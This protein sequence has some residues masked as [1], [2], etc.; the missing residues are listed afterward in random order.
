[1]PELTYVIPV[2]NSAHSIQSTISSI[3]GQTGGHSRVIVVDDGSTDE[4][5]NILSKYEGQLTLLRQPNMGPSAARNYGLEAVETEIVCFVDHDDYVIGP[6][7]SAVEISW[8]KA[9]DIIISLAAEGND[10]RIVL[11]NRNKYAANSTGDTLLRDFICDNCVQTSTISWS[12]AFLRKIGGWDQSLFGIE[13]IELAMRAFLHNPRVTILN[14][15]GWVV[16]HHHSHQHSKNLNLRLATSHL[17]MHIK[18]M[19]LME[20]NT[21]D[22]ETIQLFLQRC[23]AVGRG[24]YLNGFRDEAIEL[25]SIAWNRG[26]TEHNGPRI[27]RMLAKYCGTKITLSAR[28]IIGKMKRKCAG[29]L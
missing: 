12:T 27:E 23:M 5:A 29:F 25:F 13:D 24:L 6:Y 10:D 28:S 7:R 3:I 17:R 14:T 18:L 8:N 16:W 22:R 20:Q 21:Y 15:S 26:Y 2:H 11:S 4:T 1:M 19:S 9:A